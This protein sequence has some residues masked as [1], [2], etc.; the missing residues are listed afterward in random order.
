MRPPNVSEASIAPVVGGGAGIPDRFALVVQVG[1]G[2]D[3]TQLDLVGAG[4][5]SLP[6]GVPSDRL[7]RDR[8]AGAVR[9]VLYRRD[10]RTPEKLESAP[11]CLPPFRFGPYRDV[12][13]HRLRLSLDRVG[14]HFDARKVLQRGWTAVAGHFATYRGEEA[15]QDWRIMGALDVED[16][17]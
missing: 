6:A 16:A 12:A 14:G 3:A 15:A 17:I 4:H 10:R 13:A 1:P 11:S 7:L 8:D 2:E 5:F 9:F